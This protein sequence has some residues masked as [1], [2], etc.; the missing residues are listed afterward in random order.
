M[1]RLKLVEVLKRATMPDRTVILTILDQAW[2]RPGSV[3]HL[4][5]ESFRVGQGTQKLLNHLVVIAMDSQAFEIC[6]SVLPHCIHPSAFGSNFDTK[7]QFISNPNHKLRNHIK[8]N[9][10]LEVLDLGYNIIFT[11]ADVMWFRNPLSHFIPEHELTIS[12]SFPPSDEQNRGQIPDGGV[13]FLKAN[14]ISSEI[15]LYWKLLRVLYPDYHID[16]PLCDF[17]MQNP[18][19]TKTFGM[20]IA[21]V[22]PMYFDGF[23]QVNKDMSEVYTMHA[24]CCDDLDSKVQDLRLVLDDWINFTAGSS[25]N[26]TS[27]PLSS[28]WRAP[29]KCSG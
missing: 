2:A 3:L 26:T 11:D 17:I 28:S 10:L 4:F 19:L 18:D 1:E 14:E 21:Y 15:F 6:N 22:S 20:R 23:C 27:G 24:N 7:N 16:E 25:V 5:L 8:N 9:I 13:F 12:C 29:K